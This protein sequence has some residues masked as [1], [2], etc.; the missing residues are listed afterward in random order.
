MKTYEG[1]NVRNVAIVGH[2]HSGKTSLVSAMLYTAGS[3]QRLGRVDDGSTVTDYDEEEVARQMTISA[4]LAH[5]EWGKTKI[6]IIDTPGFNMFVHEAELAMP[7]VEAAMVVVDAVSGVQVV[8]EKIWGFA[9]KMAMP[10]VIVCTR[11]DRER[12]DFQRCMDS[13]TNAF[14]RT[15]VPVQLPIGS[16]K[17]FRGVIDLVKMKAYI[18]EMGGNGKAKVEEIPADMAAPAKEAHEKLVEAVAEGDDELMNEFFETGTIGEEHI[19]SGIHNAIRDDKIFPVLFASGLGNMGTDEVLDFIVDYMPTAVE[20]KQVAGESTPNNGEPPARKISDSD[21]LSM[22]VF[23]TV[24]DPFAGRISYFKVYSGVLKN[25]AT[26][27]NFTRSGSEKFAHLSIMQGKQAV[28]VPELHAG[29]IGA[30]AKLKETLTGDSLGDKAAPILFPTVK[31]AEPAITFAIEPKTRADEDKIGAGVHKLMEEDAML[32]FY[33]DPQTKDFLIAGTGQQ[34]IEVIVSKLKKRYHAEVVLKAPKVPYRETIRGTADVQGR[35]KKQSGGHGQYG[36]CK[37]RMEPLQRGGNFE[38]VNEIFGGAIPKNFIPAVE[39]GIVEAAQRGYL[40]GYPVVDFKV[41][42]YDGSYHDVDSNEL[43]FKTAGRIAFKKAMEV[44]KPTLLEPIMSV[45]ITVPDEF[46][47][48]IMGDLNSR[49]GRI[50]GMEN[51]GGNT[52]VKAMVP[53]SEML[54][55][56]TDLTSM[57]QGRGSFSMEMDHYDVVPAQQQEK[58]VAAAKAAKGEAAEE[59]EE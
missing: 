13:L 53:M 4:S 39:K 24:S 36:D 8:T 56:G 2:S 32:R 47:G 49:R 7:A 33:R 19:V 55:Y 31:L 45:E 38:F 21:P 14:G 59:E 30:V 5:V 25:D 35:H 23:K 41:V 34:H 10:R 43:S 18:Y 20:R 48:A 11:M 17:N 12:A 6:N 37:I 57:T 54:T 27:Q 15:V 44:A 9:D 40:A 22:F 3:T 52:I 29:D 50:G 28:P 1:A 26:V 16:E 51:K 46:A 58:I 42:L